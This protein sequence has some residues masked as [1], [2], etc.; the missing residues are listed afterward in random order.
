VLERGGDE[1]V[2][3]DIWFYERGFGLRVYSEDMVEAARVYDSGALQGEGPGAVGGA[4]E[5]SEGQCAG[6]EGS[7]RG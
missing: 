1:R 3:W 7:D 6:V 2:H 4:V 5:D